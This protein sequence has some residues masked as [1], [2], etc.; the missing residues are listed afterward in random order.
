MQNIRLLQKDVG[1]FCRIMKRWA[2]T[3]ENKYFCR[4]GLAGKARTLSI[5][6]IRD[7]RTCW[8]HS[9]RR[10]RH[11]YRSFVYIYSH[12]GT[13]RADVQAMPVWRWWGSAWGVLGGIAGP[14]DGVPRR[15]SQSTTTSTQLMRHGTSTAASDSIVVSL[16]EAT[17]SVRTWKVP[18]SRVY[19]QSTVIA[20][21]QSAS[22]L[23][24]I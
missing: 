9:E 23:I 4:V 16:P 19:A 18:R 15:R 6:R 22:C 5:Y 21:R 24:L 11:A 2:Q 17:S 13:E 1:I 3:S 10:W 12:R 14:I 20:W 8:L 7:G